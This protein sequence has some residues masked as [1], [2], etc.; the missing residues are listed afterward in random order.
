MPKIFAVWNVVFG[1]LLL[2]G[3]AALWL[4]FSA[5]ESEEDWEAFKQARHCQSVGRQ[6]G[7]N[8]GGWRCDDGKVYYRWRQQK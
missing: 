2:A 3:F 6:A 4:L 5:D 1:V 7:N 8:Q